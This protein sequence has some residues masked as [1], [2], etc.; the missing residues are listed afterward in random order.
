[1][2]HLFTDFNKTYNLVRREALYNILIEF[3]IPT[4]LIRR[5]TMCLNDTYSKV[6][7][8]KYL[9]ETLCFIAIVFHLDIKIFH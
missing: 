8:G 9:S 7:I 2:Q 1:M 5:T 6:R 3:A 4:K